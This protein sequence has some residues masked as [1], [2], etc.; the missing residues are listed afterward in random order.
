MNMFLEPAQA[1]RACK[2]TERNNKI[3]DIYINNDRPALAN[4]R[5]ARAMNMFL[6]PARLRGLAKAQKEI[7]K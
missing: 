6:E 1:A 3:N 4:M 5:L 2:S 7:I